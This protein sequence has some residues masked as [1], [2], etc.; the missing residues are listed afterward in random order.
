MKRTLAALV[1][2]VFFAPFVML[3]AFMT[4]AEQADPAFAVGTAG[5]EAEALLRN[6]RVSLSAN[7]RADLEAAIVDDRLVRLLGWIAKRH[8]IS[9]G[10][11]K[12]GHHKYV[13][14]TDR[15]SNHYYGRAADITVVDGVSVNNASLPAGQ[16]VLDIAVLEGSLRPDEVGH[17][18]QGIRFAGG[19]ADADHSGHIHLGFR[20]L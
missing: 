3:G 6:P 14:G 10:V 15:V 2:T 16:V 9:V 19:F 13:R 17:P 8:S 4:V 20:S 5:Q 18:F 12:T 7:A 11:F 1:F